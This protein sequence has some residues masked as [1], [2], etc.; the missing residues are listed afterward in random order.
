[1]ASEQR[2]REQFDG[3]PVRDAEFTTLS[4]VPLEP[5]YGPPVGDGDA[6]DRVGWPGQFPYTR[7]PYASM[8][9]SKLWTMR[10]FAG[11]GTA[12]DTNERF[13]EILAAG[14]TGLSTAF[15]L[16]TL[17]GR[18]S[19]D[20]TCEGEV[21]KCG[22]AVDT[23]A[24]ME[25]L[26]AGIDLGAVTTSM[27]I[28]SPAA[29]V[30]AMYIA[31]AERSG[32]P[33]AALGGT[34]QNDILKE[35]QAQKE[36]VFPPRPSMR[37]VADT[38]RFAAAEMPRWHPV[39]ISGY[40]IREAGSTA[41]QELAFTLANGFAY[42]ELAR[43]AGLAV[44]AF[45]PRLSFFFNA[46]IDFFEEIAKYR[47]ARRIWATWLRDRYGATDPRS[48][49]LRFHTQTAGVS[50]TAQQPELNIA[51]T[52]I[53][54]LAGVLGGT[55]SLHTNSMDEALALPTER[56]ARIALRTQQVIAHETGVAHVADPLGGSWFVEA[57]TDELEAQATAIFEHLLELGDG[58]MLEGVH[59][60][61]DTGWFQGQIS[62]AAYDLERK[63][64][65]GRRIV[66]GVNEFT[67]GNEEDQPELL[68][69]TAEQEQTQ[70]KRLQAVKAD[71]DDDA[72]RAALAVV[73]DDAERPDVNL[74]PALLTAVQTYATEGEIMDTLAEVFGR[75]VETPVL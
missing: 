13:H 26:F 69:I 14:G 33:R 54:A 37:L 17:M 51:R 60:G 1:M 10:M 71:R 29:V 49:T 18:D 57:L 23:L 68:R 72:V 44:D 50:L 11:F 66:V 38:I 75:Y 61:I 36:F 70:V 7:G 15:D 20:P 22:V 62:D 65:D 59:A 45:A 34:L 27:T 58:S 12:A 8:Y 30:L 73:R 63:L 24:D 35:Y 56:T 52:A 32:V 55:Q 6:V 43:A 9:R 74:M 2:W 53:E 5:L 16:P 4:G 40:H 67:G 47:A 25:Q 31:T 28:N 42:V 39:S 46:H 64:M 3:A 48:L 21:G 19:D 41:A